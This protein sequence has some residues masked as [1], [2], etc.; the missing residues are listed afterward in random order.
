MVRG[1]VN[2]HSDNK[3]VLLPFHIPH[4]QC[5]CAVTQLSNFIHSLWPRGAKGMCECVRAVMLMEVIKGI[6]I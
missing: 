3:Q 4:S 5:E 2:M 1:D 6:Q